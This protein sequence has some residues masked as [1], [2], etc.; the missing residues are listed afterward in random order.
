MPLFKQISKEILRPFTRDRII[1]NISKKASIN[2]DVLRR[3]IKK[4]HYLSS[5][6]PFIKDKTG[7]IIG[8][9]LSVNYG[10]RSEI[11]ILIGL[12][13]SNF[14][15]KSGNKYRLNLREILVLN[16]KEL[17]NF[18]QDI[19][20]IDYCVVCAINSKIPKDHAGSGELRC[21]GTWSNFSS[22]VHSMP[23][24]EASSFA[25]KSF[26]RLRDTPVERMIYPNSAFKVNHFG[27]LTEKLKIIKRGDLSGKILTQPG[28]TILQD[29]YENVTSC[30]HN[31]PFYRSTRL[32]AKNNW[33][34]HVIP[35]PPLDLVDIN[36][37]FGEAC[38]VGSILKISIFEKQSFNL[39]AVC[40]EEKKIKIERNE[41]LVASKIFEKNLG[42]KFYRWIKIT[43]V[44][45]LHCIGHI[46]VFYK[47][48]DDTKNFDCVHSMSF[49]NNP[50]EKIKL[51]SRSKRTLKFAPFVF[52]CNQNNH[53]YLNIF[54]D[55][56]ND[57]NIR[58]RIFSASDPSYE[59]L[60]I[61]KILAQE[62]K[63]INL[64]EKLTDEYLDK[65]VDNTFICQMEGEDS[66]LDGYLMNI[67][68]NKSK[69]NKFAIDHF[70]GG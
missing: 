70:T 27:P 38:S 37:F 1:Q 12:V 10:I 30:F 55:W 41:P 2:N 67:S 9:F 69:I 13:D 63:F 50:T 68:T 8:N 26:N 4:G 35:I 54:G 40:L 43:P 34:S 25:K 6:I 42:S 23:L 46:S 18:S 24:P 36:M 48:E 58:I 56:N 32:S 20:N 33:I 60:F 11:T 53:I 44:E 52:F 59:I 16:E 29:K 17:S 65:K 31:S 62:V 64:V 21:W 49:R 22:F 3:L 51:K 28:Y 19:E 66:N 5:Y 39:P 57:V 7:I 14:N 45:G 15:V 61:E 47:N